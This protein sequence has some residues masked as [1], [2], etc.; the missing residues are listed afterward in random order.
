MAK[1]RAKAKMAANEKSAQPTLLRDIEVSAEAQ[2]LI[3][4]LIDSDPQLKDARQGL[5][6][7]SKRDDSAVQDSLQSYRQKLQKE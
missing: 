4:E 7:S 3:E 2:K 6:F 5:R 1:A